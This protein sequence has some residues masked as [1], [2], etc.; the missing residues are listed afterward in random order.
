MQIDPVNRDLAGR[1]PARGPGKHN[2]PV[3]DPQAFKQH[4]LLIEKAGF[5]RLPDRVRT[6]TGDAL[7]DVHAVRTAKQGK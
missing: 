1:L 6:H 4:I 5:A 3:N 2:A 7:I